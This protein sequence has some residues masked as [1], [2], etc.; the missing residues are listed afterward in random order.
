VKLR[1][2]I[3]FNSE[4]VDRI[5]TTIRKN[6]TPRHVPAKC[7]EVADIPYTISGKKVELAVQNIVHGR[8][9]KNKD[10]LANPEALDYY[11]DLP[12]LKS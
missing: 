12:E 4:L 7:I 10:A 8:E 2:D 9:V 5:K 1:E 6:C 3:T 11:L